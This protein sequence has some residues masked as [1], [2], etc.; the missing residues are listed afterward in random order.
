MYLSSYATGCFST[1]TQLREDSLDQLGC[2]DA[3]GSGSYP[4]ETFYFNF[5]LRPSLFLRDLS[6]HLSVGTVNVPASRKDIP[7]LMG[8]KPPVVRLNVSI[9]LTQN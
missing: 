5:T 7:L 8:V 6:R 4:R 2:L 1:R 9:G 3:T